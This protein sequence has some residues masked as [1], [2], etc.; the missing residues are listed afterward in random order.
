[1]SESLKQLRDRFPE[2]SILSD[3]LVL[4]EQ[5]YV[6][7]VTIKVP[8]AIVVAGLSSNANLEVAEDQ[9]RQRAIEALGLGTCESTSATQV[10]PA[11]VTPAAQSREV[12]NEFEELRLSADS[13]T[14]VASPQRDRPTSIP[15]PHNASSVSDMAA[16]SQMTSTAPLSAKSPSTSIDDTNVATHDD[17]TQSGRVSSM[18]SQPTDAAAIAPVT[19]H[20]EPSKISATALPA[21]I[22][23]SDVIAQT[24]IELRRL[25]WSTETG[26]DYLEQT[27]NKRSRHELSEEELIQFLCYLEGLPSPEAM[28]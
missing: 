9:A 2:A 7:K 15:S 28:A 22:N 20:S 10:A 12:S 11:T 21:P 14:S 16:H 26:R 23:L 25:N 3:I 19:K 18:I 5:Q 6:V 4:H 8:P 17:L 24:D 1:M 27:Y 13:P